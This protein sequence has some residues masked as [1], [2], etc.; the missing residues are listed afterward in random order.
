[1]RQTLILIALIATGCASNQPPQTD[2]SEQALCPPDLIDYE[3]FDASECPAPSSLYKSACKS[4]LCGTRCGTTAC[5]GTT[6]NCDY[7]NPSG[8]GS[9]ETNIATSTA[10]CGGCNRPCAAGQTCSNGVC[11]SGQP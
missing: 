6:R 11:V 5:L 9:C 2:T 7:F 3:C 1:M 8:A 10:H 4:S